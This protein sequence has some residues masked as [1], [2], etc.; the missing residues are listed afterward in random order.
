MHPS[1][2]GGI[3][4]SK[5]MQIKP[6]KTAHLNAV[7]DLSLRAWAPVFESIQVAM[8]R[9]LFQDSYPDGWREGQR[10]AVEAVCQDENIEV[11][12]A[13]EDES[14]IG[15]TALK[16]NPDQGLGEIYMIAID[17]DAQGKGAGIAL[18]NFA[19]DRMKEAG[20]TDA[21]VETGLDPG[22]APARRIYEKAGFK[23]WPSAK[24]FK[25]L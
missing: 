4:E 25:K 24:Y 19:L 22:H 13:T 7:V 14:I 9:E 11:W 20:L 16:L 1:S 6:Y 18:T 3:S 5:A 21:M 23:M 8:D 12:V 2:R 15:F 10:A 17:P